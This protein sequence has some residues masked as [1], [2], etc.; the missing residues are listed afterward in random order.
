MAVTFLTAVMGRT[1]TGDVSFGQTP[2][3]QLVKVEPVDGVAVRVT[4]APSGKLASQVEPQ[5]I[6][7][8][9]EVTVPTPAPD[10]KTFMVLRF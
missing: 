9:I 4:E 5:L 8:G 7:A 3:N 1:Q 10:L 6:P 2:P